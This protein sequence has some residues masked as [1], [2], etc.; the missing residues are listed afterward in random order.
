MCW[1]KY[2]Y[3]GYITAYYWLEGVSGGIP[4]EYQVRAKECKKCGKVKT[5]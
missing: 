4:I 5:I 2:E 1:H 3:V